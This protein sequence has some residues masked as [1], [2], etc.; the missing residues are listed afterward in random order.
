MPKPPIV[1]LTLAAVALAAGGCGGAATNSTTAT[2]PGQQAIPDVRGMNAPDAVVRLLKARYC[3]KLA[4]G[5]P[6]PAQ[7]RMPVQQQSPAAG[8]TGRRWSTVT[9]TIGLPS[10]RGTPRHRAVEIGVETWG[11]ARAPCP[12]IRASG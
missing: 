7:K 9:L 3:V 6:V 4:V 11:G 8:S 5:K 10:R 1:L 12:P 2:P